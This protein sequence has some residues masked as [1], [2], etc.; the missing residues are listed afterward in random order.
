MTTNN[1]APF[2]RMLRQLNDNYHAELLDDNA[3]QMYA[4]AGYRYAVL[5]SG[6]TLLEDAFEITKRFS[7]RFLHAVPRGQSI[8]AVFCR[9]SKEESGK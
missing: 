7:F 4:A 9:Q 8:W 5:V 2:D 3:K 6:D 1:S